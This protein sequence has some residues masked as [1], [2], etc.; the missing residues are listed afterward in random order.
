MG[1]TKQVKRTA[2]GL[3]KAERDALANRRRIQE[4][5]AIQEIKALT[6]DDALR[7]IVH[8]S[9]DNPLVLARKLRRREDEGGDSDPILTYDES[10]PI[11]DDLVRK[12]VELKN[13]PTDKWRP[14][15]AELVFGL[16]MNV[17]LFFEYGEPGDVREC[18]E[19]LQPVLETMQKDGTYSDTT[20]GDTMWKVLGEGEG[21]PQDASWDLVTLQNLTE[22]NWLGWIDEVAKAKRR[23]LRALYTGLQFA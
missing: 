18:I 1:R 3:P 23:E 7:I 12:I 6:T 20:D 11:T 14:T 19:L 5:A 17:K 13:E 22:D 21:L 9:P 2:T 16:T 15:P 8:T 10:E 4:E